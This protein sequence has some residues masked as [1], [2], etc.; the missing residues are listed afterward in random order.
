MYRPMSKKVI[1]SPDAP[2]A[3]GPYSQGIRVGDFV[4]LAGQIPTIP[5]T[6]E[7]PAGGITEQAE[8]VVANIK[9]LLAAE[10]LTLANVVKS[11]VFL[12]DLADF[13]AM[14]AVYA[15][16]FTAPFPARSTF[17]VA[18]LPKGAKVEIEVVA[19]A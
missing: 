1:S 14:N 4:F 7:F 6:G 3:V 19:H 5:A 8:Q 9:A 12:A 15:K 13:A 11:S 2:Q 10:G 16:H 17:Q 18:G